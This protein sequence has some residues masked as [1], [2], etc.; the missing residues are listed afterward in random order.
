MKYKWDKKYLHWGVTAFLVIAASACFI[1]L[2]TRFSYCLHLFNSVLRILTPIIIGFVITWL[3]AP[4][5]NW[6][7]RVFFRPLC[8]RL[9]KKKPQSVDRVT[10]IISV[11]ITMVVFFLLVAGLL[12]LVLPQLYK[13]IEKLVTRLPDYSKVAVSWIN[14]KIGE[15]KNAALL[16]KGFDTV[17]SWLRSWME[18]SLLP[19]IDTIIKLITSSVFTVLKALVQTLIGFVLSVYIL[20]NKETFSA[21]ARKLIFAVVRKP[22]TGNKILE[23]LRFINRSFGHYFIGTLAASLIVG[24]CTAIFMLITGMPYVALISVIVAVT[25]IIPILGPYI[26]AIPSAFLIL[27][28]NPLQS[29][30]FIAFIVI[31]QTIDGNVITPKIIGYQTGLSGFWIITAIT[32][33]GSLFGFGGMVCAVPI[34]AVLY[35]GISRLS[36]ARLKK[37]SLP[38]DTESYKNLDSINTETQKPNYKE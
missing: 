10:R 12:F 28:E 34:C 1:L 6:S 27:L 37:K 21:Q 17:A 22:S 16:S 18:T 25:N 23:G 32:I 4:V 7:E 20:F 13:S 11:T 38:S 15:S 31:L 5:V 19:R 35:T 24:V 2:I 30:V 9:C 33:G 26:G 36:A 29:L 14:D 8:T 3:L